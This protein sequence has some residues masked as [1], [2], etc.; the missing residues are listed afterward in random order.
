MI[1]FLFVNNYFLFDYDTSE[2]QSGLDC[3]VLLNANFRHRLKN[4]LTRQGRVCAHKDGDQSQPEYHRGTRL[5][6]DRVK[7]SN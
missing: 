4:Q 5:G 7:P 2:A 6:V 1:Y 3:V